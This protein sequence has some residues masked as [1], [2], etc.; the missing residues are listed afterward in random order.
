MG[1]GDLSNTEVIISHEAKLNGIYETEVWDKSHTHGW[2][3]DKYFILSKGNFKQ[4]K[5]LKNLAMGYGNLSNGHQPIRT[6]QISLR[7]DKD[8]WWPSCQ[9]QLAVFHSY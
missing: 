8:K 3:L 4:N 7:W 1:Y 2:L 5:T 6:R 9:S